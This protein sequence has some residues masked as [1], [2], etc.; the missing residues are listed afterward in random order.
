MSSSVC[1][2]ELF[3][4]T[5][6]DI[7]VLSEHKLFN[8][9]LQF[10]NTL[11]NNYHSLG[12]AD[13]SVN[14]ET[15]KCG[16]GGVAIM[17]KKTLKFNIKPINCPVS[18]R[19]LGIEIQCNENYSI[20]VFSVYLPADSNIQNYKYEMN[21]VEDYVSNFSKFGPVIVAGDFNTSCRV[22]DLDRTNVNKSIV[23]S[24][25]ML[26]NNI[27]PVNASTLCDASSFT[28]IPTRTL[29]D[30]F[31]VSEELAGDVISCE[32]IPEGTLSLTSDHLPVFLKLSIP[33]VCNSTNGCNNVWPSWRKASESSL[34]AYNELTNKIADELLDLPLCNLSDL[35]TLAC[36]LT[37]K[38]K[39]CA[40]ETIPSGSFNPKTKPYWSDEVKQ[41]HTAERLAHVYTPT[42]N[43]KFDNDFKVH[44]TEFVDR[45]L[46]SCATN[47]GLLPGG[48]ITLYEIE[49]V[50][51]NLKLRKAPGYD[52][53]QNEHVRY[54]GKKLHTVILRIFNAVIRFGRIPLCWKH[55]L[56]IPLFKGYRTELDL[57]FNLGDKSVNIST[58]T[59]HL[60]I[61]R[62]VDLSPSTDIQHSCRK[63]RN[64]YFAIAGTGSCLLNP[65]TVCGLYNKIVIPAVLYGCELWN[66]IKPK[67]IRCLE[68]FQHF[69]VKHIQGF[70][71]RT[72]SDMCESMTNLERLPI[73]VEKRKLMF[74]YKLCEMKAQSLTKQIFIYRLFQYFGDT[75]RKQHGFIPD[76]TNILSKYSLLNFLNSYMFTGCFPTKLQ[77]KNIV[78]SAINQDEKHRKEERMRS[79][80]DFTRFLRLSENNG[81]DFIWQYAKYTGRLRTAKHVAKLWS[82]PPTSGNC[83]LCGHFVQDTLYHQIRMCTE[84]QTQRHLLYKRLSE[85]TSDNFLYTLLSKSDEYVSCFL[86]GNHEALLD[87]LTPEHCLDVL[88]E[89]FSYLKYCRL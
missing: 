59:K 4:Y 61:L 32:N 68:T 16:K 80:N 46:E 24:D 83:N 37:D 41:A 13:T 29:L 11:D 84:L 40:N 60:G 19:I 49:T 50:V 88:N 9:S 67:D 51:R 44:V 57:V 71:K 66:G 86:L 64:A 25:F 89:G 73:L 20:F 6:C 81:Y 38:L 47:N 55:G 74:L 31:L 21:I 62:T 8:H 78:N 58:E 35:D 53:L 65:L 69:I 45:T 82:T 42:E 54:S 17:Y 85:M 34:G 87:F 56:L 22:T 75:S 76:V 48:E 14:I 5:N 52:K 7:A 30:Y 27:I 23:F 39:D 79:D 70:P 3:K 26:R 1:L 15:S 33:Y 36:K 77:W 43:S 63:G 28:Y 2:S 10:L 18:E 12:I 72:R